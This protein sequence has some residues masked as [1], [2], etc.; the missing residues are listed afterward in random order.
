MEKKEFE[1][2]LKSVETEN[3]LDLYFY[4]PVGYQIA[5]V[6]RHT[7]ITPNMVTVLSIFVGAGTGYLFYFDELRYI[8]MGIL[9]LIA[10]NILDCVDGQLAR[11]TGKKSEIGRIL[12]GIAGDIWF[13]LIYTGLALRLTHAC[14][15]AWVFVPAVLSGVSHLVQANITDYYKTL[16][17]FFMSKEKGREFQNMEQVKAQQKMAKKGLNKLFYLLYEGYTGFQETLTPA[18]QR[19]LKNLRAK[20]GEEIPEEIRLD[21]RRQS[22]LLMER[23]INYLTFNGRT[24]ILFVVVLSGYVWIYF[25]YEAI[26]LNFILFLSIRKHEKMCEKIDERIAKGLQ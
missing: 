22:C 6:I 1:S 2:S 7:R 4:R 9:L 3:A 15:T 13:I 19:L 10:A 12:D 8:L 21:F 18:L 24:I 5:R 25:I 23:Y 17:L 16:H 26:V 11:L 14:G 20:Y